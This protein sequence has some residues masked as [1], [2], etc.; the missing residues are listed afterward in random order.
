[1]QKILVPVLFGRPKPANQAAP[2]RRMVGM[3]AMVSTL[4][5]VRRPAVEADR[6]RERRLEPRLALLALEALEQPGLLA[7]DIGAGAAVQ[8]DLVV[9]A[10]AAGVLADQ[11]RRV[12]LV[13]RRLRD[14]RLA[15]VLAA[16]IDV[17]GGGA[18]PD[19]GEQAAFD[20]LVR[21]VAHDLAVLAGA[22]LAL[23]GVDHQIAWPVRLL[24]HERHLEAGRKAGAAA[25][26]QARFLDLLDDPVAPLRDQRFGAVPVAPPARRCQAPVVLAVEVGEDPV[27]VSQHRGPSLA[28][29]RARR[30][31]LARP[32]RCDRP[33]HGPAA[34]AARCAW[35]AR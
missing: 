25:A 8:V 6:R 13:D 31:W 11:A 17:A 21:V 1:M 3:T 2:R 14:L 28:S 16:D 24:G 20:Q 9:V 7:A 23:V 10:R 15:D 4:L 34:P 19:P 30:P 22:G 26:A 5:T 12:G 32:A 27:L 35:R 18:H 29:R 33:R